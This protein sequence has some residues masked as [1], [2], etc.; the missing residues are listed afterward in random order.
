[1]KNKV[2]SSIITVVLVGLAAANFVSHKASH[3]FIALP[4]LG[5]TKSS[6]SGT[7]MYWSAT[8]SKSILTKS[9]CVLEGGKYYNESLTQIGSTQPITNQG[10]ES[11]WQWENDRYD[12]PRVFEMHADASDS[13][14]LWVVFLPHI[15]KPGTHYNGLLD[16]YYAYIPNHRL[17]PAPC[18]QFWVLAND[19]ASIDINSYHPSLQRS[20]FVIIKELKTNNGILNFSFDIWSS[21]KHKLFS[22][23]P[24]L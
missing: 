18:Q 23:I 3:A 8:F 11:N 6:T 13:E 10:T 4:D 1:M 5:Y 16:I 24:S 14:T 15:E 20:F 9:Y 2:I 19:K 22:F 7:Y 17:I 12:A 21:T